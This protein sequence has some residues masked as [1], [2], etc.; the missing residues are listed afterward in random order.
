MPFNRPSISLQKPLSQ[1][2]KGQNA[3][4]CIIPFALIFGIVG[5]GLLWFLFLV[6]VKKVIEAQNWPSISC[7]IIS[8]QIHT[9]RSSDGTTYRPDISYTYTLN[10]QTYTSDSYSFGGKV[11]STYNWAKNRVSQFPVGSNHI[12][13]VDPQDPQQAVLDRGYTGEIFFGLMGLPFLLVPVIIIIAA[14]RS[15][16]SSGKIKSSAWQPAVVP[17][18]SASPSGGLVLQNYGGTRASK[19]AVF[20]FIAAFWNGIVL[21][22]MV[23]TFKSSSGLAMIIPGLFMIPFVLIGIGLIVAFLAQVGALFNPAIIVALSRDGVRVGESLPFNWE[24]KGA[25]S[26]LNNVKI[27]LE[28]REEATF[29]RGT[30]TVTDKS[31]FF[32]AVLVE[33]SRPINARGEAMITIPSGTMH[34]FEASN[35]KILWILTFEAP[36]SRWPDVREEWKI[37]VMPQ[38]TTGRVEMDG[39]TS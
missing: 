36:I 29:R 31:T 34:S 16:G 10:G 21:A 13:Y 33:E 38:E 1:R 6:P 25:V 14:I 15:R 20:F 8:S 7:R 3:I 27:T 18:I 22:F 2:V 35:N 4:G 19:A 39:G 24:I 11:S 30:D 5:A 37:N 28:G 32:H 26:R 12:C 23:P 17:V 9:S